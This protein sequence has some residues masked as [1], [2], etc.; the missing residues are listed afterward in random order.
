MQPG[1]LDL[2]AKHGELVA[3]D[4]QL[5]FGV[6]GD[7]TKLENASDDRVEKRVKHGGGCYESARRRGE[8]N[9]RARQVRFLLGRAC[10]AES[11]LSVGANPPGS[12]GPLH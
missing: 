12:S 7:P 4:E 3:Q 5:G 10:L 9:F 2:P 11:A 6:R 1:A 8:S